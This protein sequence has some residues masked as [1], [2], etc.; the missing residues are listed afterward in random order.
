MKLNKLLPALALILLSGW[1]ASCIDEH[2]PYSSEG[3]KEKLVS[4]SVRV[5]GSGAPKTYALT[6][7]DENEVMNIVIL[8]FGSD[9]KYTYQ[10]IY[11]NKITTDP[12]DSRIKTFTAKVPEGTYDLMI[13]ANGNTIV[14]NALSSI[15]VGTDTKADV[16]K[17]LL[18]SNPGKWNS[19]TGSGSYV[20]IPMWGETGT[21]NVNSSL[22][23]TNVSLVRMI[24]KVDV[25]LIGT[26]TQAKFKLKS[27][28]LYNY[29]DKGQIAPD[30]PN[31]DP[32]QKVVT[33]PSVPSTASKPSNP[34]QNSLVYSGASIT[35]TDISCIGEI[36]TFEAAAGSATD[37]QKNTC[38]VIG[39][40]Y[41]GGPET[42][43]RVDFANT[44]SGTTTYLALLRNHHYRVNISDVSAPGL[45]SAEDAFKSVPANIKA[46]IVEWSDG[47]FTDFAVNDQYV[48]GVSQG[49]FNLFRD[50]YT[51]NSSNNILSIMTDYPHGWEITKITD[52]ADSPVNWLTCSVKK[53]AGTPPSGDDIRLLLDA[54]DTGE[55]RTA[56]IHITAD[57][58]RLVYKV[59][60]TQDILADVGIRITD[61]SN[62]EIS[63]LEFSAAKDVQPAAQQI[64]LNWTPMTS[65]VFVN[66]SPIKNGGFTFDTSGGN[67]QI[68]SGSI[69][70][71]A[72]TKAYTLQP[73]AITSADLASDPFYERTSVVLYS[74]SDGIITSNKALT[75]RQFVYNVV[76]V[77]AGVYLM[78]GGQK[79]FGVRSN[80]PFTVEVDENP[81]N[82][83]SLKTKAGA[84]NTSAAGTPVYF[85]IIDDQTNPT[86]FQKNVVLK[87]KSPQNHFAETKVTLN[88]AS[89]IIQPESN[90]YIVAPGGV[91]ILIPV[92]RANASDIG[93]QLTA[94]EDFTAE[95]VWT[96]NSNGVANNSNIRLIKPI[97][98]ST[99]VNDSYVLVM[100]GTADGNAVVAIKNA[101]NKILWSWHIWVTNYNPDATLLNGWMDRNLGAI[102]NT[103]GQPKTMGLLY[104]WGR[105]DPFT[106][107]TA[108]NGIIEL[109]IYNA[110]G[111]TTTIVKAIV[112]ASPNLSNAV[113]N[114]KTFYY[115][116]SPPYDWYSANGAQNDNL[117]TTG[118]AKSVYDPCPSGYRVPFSKSSQTPWTG[119]TVATF[120][121]NNQ[122]YGRTNADVGGFYPAAGIR[123]AS[124]GNLTSAS[125][126]GY[127]WTASGTTSN[128]AYY[129]MFSGSGIDA[130][131]GATRGLG[132]SVR[133][134]RY[135][136]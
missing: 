77:T 67:D 112:P 31:W 76:P 49:E 110:S 118:G 106:G 94:S 80:A 47:K 32:I 114:P 109:P 5:P 37:L 44:S 6:D 21:I 85:D 69:N 72:G 102:G 75:L 108:I 35:T 61:T 68:T 73:P 56:Y 131:Y 122:T 12:G 45:G 29:N 10:P 46:G 115:K 43:Y 87:I 91:G 83:I 8:L 13:L 22:S 58:G 34:G 26:T 86:L 19:D 107:P 25:A 62:K 30:D 117:W 136:F 105:K 2:E 119:L 65:D 23:N 125:I 70:E 11:N 97:R 63:V 59:K 4:F 129:L 93:T 51:A 40:E 95:L 38:L 113:A 92:S 74:I 134:I 120:P 54:N 15:T 121:W 81:D 53:G 127:Y 17:K 16:I 60:V 89:G 126:G 14:G 66:V 36:Y 55:R 33:A 1:L 132:A 99:S 116:S 130:V 24:A 20:P 104:Q 90:S 7:T 9:G 18:S 88:C 52:A 57:A 50:K 128:N 3:G 123:N 135:S 28:R 98:S 41:N 124:G 78:D 64:K 101:S 48:L 82:V 96:D 42:F 39:G 103:P 79:S 27:V 84:P 100:P 133:C 111:A 71:P